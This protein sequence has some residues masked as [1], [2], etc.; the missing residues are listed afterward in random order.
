MAPYVVPH[1]DQNTGL[2]F[3]LFTHCLAPFAQVVSWQNSP[4]AALKDTFYQA[5][6][7]ADAKVNHPPEIGEIN[8]SNYFFTSC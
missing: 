7:S 3:M 4:K 2:S 8:H 1:S 5:G 6:I